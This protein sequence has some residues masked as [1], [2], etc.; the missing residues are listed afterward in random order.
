MM[1][2]P[3]IQA[4]DLAAGDF[5]E[6]GMMAEKD[7]AHRLAGVLQQ[8]LLAESAY[9][10]SRRYLDAQW[11]WA[12]G[13]LG[14]LHQLIRWFKMREPDTELFLITNGSAN[15][16]FLAALA[17]FLTIIYPHQVTPSMR[18]EMMHNAVYFGC[19]DG[20]HSLVQFYKMIERECE[21]IHLLS[22]GDDERARATQYLIELGCEEN[23][24]FVALQARNTPNDPLRNATAE[25]LDRALAPYIGRGWQ[26]INTGLEEHPATAQYPSVRS[27]A[28]P[29]HASF[30]LS[31]TCDQFIGSNSGA[32]VIAHAYQRPVEIINDYAQAAWIYP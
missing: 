12:M 4:L 13:H 22:L 23:R 21:S 7:T 30:L 20:F 10:K 28:D 11:A 1:Y 19:P 15:N 26:I 14:L 3:S 8:T 31:A 24:P 9:S 25:Q 18:E 27:L 6:R 2:H 32:W 16:H 5:H 29:H 17:P